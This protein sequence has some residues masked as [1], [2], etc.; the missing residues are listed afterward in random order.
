MSAQRHR[1]ERVHH[2]S[3][4]RVRGYDVLGSVVSTVGRTTVSPFIVERQ[5]NLFDI[6]GCILQHFRGYAKY[7]T[8]G[9][10]RYFP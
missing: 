2:D 6:G 10:E 9:M 5:L 4:Q 7:S 3:F 1:K 8:C